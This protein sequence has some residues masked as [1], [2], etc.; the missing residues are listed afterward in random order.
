VD[1]SSSRSQPQWTRATRWRAA[2]IED[3]IAE[4][5]TCRQVQE[6]PSLLPDGLIAALAQV[7]DDLHILRN[8]QA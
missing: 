4:F 2:A 7:Q 1:S 8:Q 6:N 3:A 5:V